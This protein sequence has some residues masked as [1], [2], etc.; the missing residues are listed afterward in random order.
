MPVD[1]A[2]TKRHHLPLDMNLLVTLDALLSEGSVAGAAQRLNL[3]SPAMS[4]QLARIRHLLGDPVLV[5]AG[6]GLVPTPRAEG[7]RERLRSL[8][9]EAEALVRG[10]DELDLTRLERIFVIR[11][12]DGFI[13]TFGA[14]MA[15]HAAAQAPRV[16][17][18]FA[19]QESEDVEALREGRIDVDVG[20]IGAMGPEIRLQALFHDRF[21]G[22]VR[23]GHPLAD[24]V[25]AERF[26]AFP[27]V[28]VSRRGRFAGPIDAALAAVGLSRFVAIAVA[29]FADALA[30]ARTSDHVAAVP[31]RLTEPARGGLHTFELP[32]KTDALA[33]SLAWHPRVDA[34]LAHRWLR[35]IMRE[36]CAAGR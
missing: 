11:A 23:P 30:I 21:V 4:R 27:H 36:A 9:A 2:S 10:E 31:A 20:V 29:D 26:C 17:L 1:A 19:H 25:T 12:N 8:V 18:R 15:A 16:R 22:V 24:D 32:V 34:D 33:I 6:R 13:G 35:A 7:L 28:S 14:A 3:S 5:R